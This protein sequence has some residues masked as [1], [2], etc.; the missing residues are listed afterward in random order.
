M[1]PLDLLISPRGRND[2]GHHVYHGQDQRTTQGAGD[3]QG[4]RCGLN[5]PAK[6]DHV[7]HSPGEKVTDGIRH[8]SI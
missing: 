5:I 3:R 1:G 6:E 4:N 2:Q 8:D 7:P